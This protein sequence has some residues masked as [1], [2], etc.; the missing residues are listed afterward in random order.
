[1]RGSE[2]RSIMATEKWSMMTTKNWSMAVAMAIAMAI[3][4]MNWCGV[5]NCGGIGGKNWSMVDWRMVDWS[6]VG[7][8]RARFRSEGE[9]RGVRHGTRNHR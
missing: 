8:R 6:V 4:M 9:R 1:M 3:S 7:L 5:F 2:V